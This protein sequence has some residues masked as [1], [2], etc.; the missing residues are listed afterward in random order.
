MSDEIELRDPWFAEAKT[1][2][3]ETLPAFIQKLVD[4]PHDYGTSCRAIAA[5]ALGAAWAVEHSP[6][7]AVTG[8]Q[9][10]CVMWDFMRGWDG[11]VGPAVLQRYDSL[12]FPQYEDSWC[13]LSRSGFEWVQAEARKRLA[14]DRGYMD[15][16][17]RAHMEAI[18]AGVVPFGLRLGLR[19]KD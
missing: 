2:T 17:V 9:G 6:A 10:S 14:E 19:L 15:K 5:A 3:L 4:H 11:L 7:G 1:Q 18:V 12:L 13:A 8:L 16:D